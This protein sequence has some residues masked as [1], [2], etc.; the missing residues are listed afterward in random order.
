MP[1]R[2]SRRDVYHCLRLACGLLVLHCP[3]AIAQSLSVT[4]RVS[5]TT[6]VVRQTSIGMYY[7]G[8]L[9]FTDRLRATAGLRG[10]LYRFGVQS[11]KPENAGT[12]LAGL[13]S[14]KL[15]VVL[16]PSGGLELYGNFGYGY[17]SNDGRGTTISV[18][19][20][21]GA[22]V[23]TVTPLARTR[24]GEFGLRTILIPKVQTTVAVWGLSLD[25]ELVFVGDAG[26]TEPGRPSRRAGVEWTNSYTPRP[27][28]LFE[29]DLSWSSARFT[30][31]A[32]SGS[33]VPG[34]V[35]HV[36]SFDASVSDYRRIS[37][38]LRLRYLGPRPL[39]E[40]ATVASRRSFVGHIEVAYRVAP[41]LRVL[42]D[43]LNVFDSKDSDIEYYYSSRLTGE[44]P[45]GI[46][47]IHTHPVQPRTARIGVQIDF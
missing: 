27:W 21:T 40:N 37:A 14:P 33:S 44:P 46:D 6:G 17:H 16:A 31:D 42:V 18:D 34:A 2:R 24:G 39:I 41:R 8:E 45:E 7:Q 43:L 29:A 28:L 36:A 1:A 35:R 19:P 38:G 10:D 11:T 47:N 12:E 32:S 15:G 3:P 4:G 23:D 22:R 13:L 9:E 26:T 30:D 5:D 25:S 20:L